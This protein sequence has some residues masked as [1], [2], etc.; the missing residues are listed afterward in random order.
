MF[1]DQSYIKSEN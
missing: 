1:E